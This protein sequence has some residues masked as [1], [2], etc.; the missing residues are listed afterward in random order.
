MIILSFTI[1]EDELVG[2]TKYEMILSLTEEQAKLTT[3][4]TPSMS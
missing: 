1:D 2:S 4:S 3:S